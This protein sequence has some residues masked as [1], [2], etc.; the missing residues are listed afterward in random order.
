[1][2]DVEAEFKPDFV[3]PVGELA[4]ISFVVC[5]DLEKR[6]WFAFQRDDDESNEKVMA[7]LAS[8]NFC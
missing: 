6:K 5:L 1:M 2:D 7:Q 8:E 3:G 4:T